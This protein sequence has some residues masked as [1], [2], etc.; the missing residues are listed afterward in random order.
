MIIKGI[1]II[2]CMSENVSFAFMRYWVKEAA[3]NRLSVLCW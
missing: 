1:Y 2:C 3:V